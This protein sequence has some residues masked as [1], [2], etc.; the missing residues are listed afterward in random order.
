MSNGEFTKTD[1]LMAGWPDALAEA[2]VREMEYRLGLVDGT[3]IKFRRATPAAPPVT[4]WVHLSKV[5]VKFPGLDP[6]KERV[7]FQ[8]G[9]DVRVDRIVWAAKFGAVEIPPVP[10]V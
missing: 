2:A 10:A 5:Q 7:S 4:G 6:N 9:I 8:D 1:L 3:A